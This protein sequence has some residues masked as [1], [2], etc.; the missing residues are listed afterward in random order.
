[1]FAAFY[2]LETSQYSALPLAEFVDWTA[3]PG[4]RSGELARVMHGGVPL[5]MFFVCS[6]QTEPV[7]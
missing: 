7:S 6:E 2:C 3:N 5:T 1:M 4:L